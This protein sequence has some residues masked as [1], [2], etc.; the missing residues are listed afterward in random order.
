MKDQFR[1]QRYELQLFYIRHF[2]VFLILYAIAL[3]AYVH[4]PL[5]DRL[6]LMILCIA[7][8]LIL[9]RLF[10][11]LF[12]G[13]FMSKN[14]NG[15]HEIVFLPLGLIVFICYMVAGMLDLQE[16]S[17]VEMI[18]LIG[19]IGLNIY[20]I[21]LKHYVKFVRVNR[22]ADYMAVYHVT[23]GNLRAYRLWYLATGLLVLSVAILPMWKALNRF[24]SRIIRNLSERFNLANLNSPTIPSTEPGGATP[25]PT[26][27]AFLGGGGTVPDA[28]GGLSETAVNIIY[29]L[30]GAFLLFATYQM[31]R[32]LMTKITDAK[33]SMETDHVIDLK[34]TLLP[35]PDEVVRVRDDDVIDENAY[36]RKIRRTFKRTVFDKFGDVDIPEKT[37]E[38]LLGTGVP[39]E[40]DDIL[41][42]KYEKARYS[43]IPCTPEDVKAVKPAK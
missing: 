10:A 24:W 2:S 38:E 7:G 3:V 39:Q 20:A 6:W 14:K 27:D 28:G 37:P 25:T 9:A 40:N 31:V 13:M 19:F 12:T 21:Y 26:P 41:L 23:L 42:E 43:N 4:K 33:T 35:I 17:W 22:D 36:A 32:I 30:V 34:K 18:I 15:S 1:I 11:G 5:G 29:I 8:V 16:V